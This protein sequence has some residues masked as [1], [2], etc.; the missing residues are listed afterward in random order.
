MLRL[1]ATDSTSMVSPNPIK[2]SSRHNRCKSWPAVAARDL[3]NPLEE[4]SLEDEDGYERMF[5]TAPLNPSS[6]TLL[7]NHYRQISVC[8]VDLKVMKIRDPQLLSHVQQG[9]TR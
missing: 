8:V 9:E 1:T 7:R 3:A 4:S 6:L 2:S 5:R